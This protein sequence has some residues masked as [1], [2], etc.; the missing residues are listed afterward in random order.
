ML[1][2]NGCS[3]IVTSGEKVAVIFFRSSGM[4]FET[5]HTRLGSDSSKIAARIWF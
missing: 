3:G 1:P 2:K 5:W 4:I